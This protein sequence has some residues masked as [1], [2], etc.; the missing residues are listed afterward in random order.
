MEETVLSRYFSTAE[1]TRLEQ[2]Q[3]RLAQWS[4]AL[5]VPFTAHRLRSGAVAWVNCRWFLERGFDLSSKGALAQ[6][7]AWLLDE[8]AWCVRTDKRGFTA[9]TKTLWA[10]RYGSVDGMSPHGGSGRVATLGCFQGKGIGQTPLVGEGA[11]PG[12]H[13]W[14]SV[15]FRVPAR[16]NLG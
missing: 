10:D 13:T 3:P 8:F 15:A 4:T 2:G 11:S 12:A 14:V 9:D 16:S 1:I 5:L 7:N 6:V